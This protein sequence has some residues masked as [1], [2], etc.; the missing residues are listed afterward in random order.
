MSILRELPEYRELIKKIVYKYNLGLPL[1]PLIEEL[2]NK[3]EAPLSTEN[4]DKSLDKIWG[5]MTFANDN[6]EGGFF[7][8]R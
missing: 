8:L 1:K 7:K 6:T 2:R 4:I 3:I 5:G